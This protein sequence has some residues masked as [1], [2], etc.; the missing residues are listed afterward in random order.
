MP[1]LKNP[2]AKYQAGKVER[3]CEVIIKY[4][5][6]LRRTKNRFEYVTDLAKNVAMQISLSEKKPCSASTLLRNKHYKVLLLNFMAALSGTAAFN[7]SSVT[8][9]A[10]RD[11]IRAAQLELGNLRRENERL[12]SHIS[13]LEKNIAERKI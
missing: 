6:A 7:I 8:D 3:R 10:A 5:A 4:L 9:H 12:H 13:S 11:M 2:F 1:K